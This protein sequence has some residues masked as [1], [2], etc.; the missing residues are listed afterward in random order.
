M[1]NGR[2]QFDDK[3]EFP[4]VFFQL[5]D[6]PLKMDIVKLAAWHNPGNELSMWKDFVAETRFETD[7]MPG[8]PQV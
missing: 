3:F 2:W 1:L 5:L 8:M 7:I 6:D 4:W